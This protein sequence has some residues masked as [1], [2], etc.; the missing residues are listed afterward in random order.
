MI[1]YI[2]R[3]FTT[4]HTL[5]IHKSLPTPEELF[6]KSGNYALKQ[7]CLQN[8]DTEDEILIARGHYCNGYQQAIKDFIDNQYR[9]LD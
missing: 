4:L 1:R 2:R 9:G 6:T 5:F 7:C 3:C 8:F